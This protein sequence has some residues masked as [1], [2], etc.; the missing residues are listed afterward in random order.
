MN[1]RDKIY[2]SCE[3]SSENEYERRIADNRLS[4]GD[5]RNIDI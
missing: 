1:V 3:F 5:A 4:T 2:V